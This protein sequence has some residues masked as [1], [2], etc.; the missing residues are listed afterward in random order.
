MGTS[1]SWRTLENMEKVVLACLCL[2]QATGQTS[3]GGQGP[4]GSRLRPRIP[5]VGGSLLRALPGGW[6]PGL[7]SPALSNQQPPLWPHQAL[8]QHSSKA[9]GFGI[10]HPALAPQLSLTVGTGTPFA[11]SGP[12]SVRLLKGRSGL[13]NSCHHLGG[14]EHTLLLN[15]EREPRL[16]EG[17]TD[18]TT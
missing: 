12:Q 4:S 3:L 14:P 18:G 5:A 17:L 10:Q 7:R 6:S 16:R 2:T 11:I 13:S 9:P 1:K 8:C 15:P